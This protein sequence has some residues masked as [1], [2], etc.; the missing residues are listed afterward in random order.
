[1]IMKKLSRFPPDSK[2]NSKI[3][4]AILFVAI[5]TIAVLSILVVGTTSAVTQQLKLAKYITDADTSCYAASSALEIIRSFFYNDASPNQITLY[6][7]RKRDIPQGPVTLQVSLTDEQ[8]LMNLHKAD[9]A[10]LSRLPGLSD[11]PS[12]VDQIAAAGANLSVKEDIL[13]LDGASEE[14][15]K[16]FKDEL[17]IFGA[18]A[19]NINTASSQALQYLGMDEALS[20]KII[21][22]RNGDDAVE[23]TQD[24]RIFDITANIVTSLEPYGLSSEEITLLNSTVASGLLATT[25][26]F[27]R[28]HIVVEK[29]GK[30][31]AVYEIVM[32]LGTGKAVFWKEA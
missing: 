18:G 6:D 4:G 7:L 29:A 2:G 3:R 21:E 28:L 27:I 22:F 24:D 23:A 1:M 15:Y 19:V 16:Q 25:S 9:S 8:A 14:V 31:L 11:N 32:N 17:T 30:S 5:G 10:M 20:A 13:L 12:C 26:S